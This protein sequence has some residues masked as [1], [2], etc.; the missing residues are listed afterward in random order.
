MKHKITALILLLSSSM[1][2]AS[3]N[4]LRM[5]DKQIKTIE[6]ITKYRCSFNA[7]RKNKFRIMGYTTEVDYVIKIMNILENTDK[8]L[9]YSSYVDFLNDRLSEKS[10]NCSMFY[11]GARK[12]SGKYYFSSY[13]KRNIDPTR[14][15]SDFELALNNVFYNKNPDRILKNYSNNKI[16]KERLIWLKEFKERYPDFYKNNKILLWYRVNSFLPTK[17]EF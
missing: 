14:G 11:Y 13:S 7:E 4:Y 3:P 5:L 15:T 2:I 10:F 9:R 6:L 12:L 17:N 1:V 8:K 16:I